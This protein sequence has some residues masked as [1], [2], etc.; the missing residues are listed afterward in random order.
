MYIFCSVSML[1]QILFNIFI[2]LSGRFVVYK[3]NLVTC[4]HAKLLNC[5]GQGMNV[6]LLRFIE[7]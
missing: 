4:I 2:M 3:C 1:L 5:F 6:I 7:G